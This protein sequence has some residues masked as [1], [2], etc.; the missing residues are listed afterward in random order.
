VPVSLE[1]T[2]GDTV[3]LAPFVVLDYAV[4]VSIFGRR[5]IRSGY[6]CGC[7]GSRSDSRRTGAELSGEHTTG[8]CS[9]RDNYRTVSFRGTGAAI[10]IDCFLL[11]RV[12]EQRFVAHDAM[13]LDY[14][15][16]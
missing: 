8:C 1:L 3:G 13:L 10:A 14:V 4:A 2:R 15:L 5:P 12:L 7:C 16:A 9:T 11:V 6:R